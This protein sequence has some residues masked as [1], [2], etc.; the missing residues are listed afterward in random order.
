MFSCQSDGKQATAKTAVLFT[1]HLQ[2]LRGA[3]GDVVKEQDRMEEKVGRRK[4]IRNIHNSHHFLQK[5]QVP[6]SLDAAFKRRLS[7]LEENNG[8][9]MLHCVAL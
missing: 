8:K 4:T 7:R 5:K 3:D 1:K 2:D 6:L 9:D